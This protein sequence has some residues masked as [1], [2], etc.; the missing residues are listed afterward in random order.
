VL[1]LGNGIPY[2]SN[3]SGLSIGD[4]HQGGII[5]YLGSEYGGTGLIVSLDNAGSI[6]RW[7]CVTTN[8]SGATGHAIGTGAQN[9]S[10]IVAA[11]CG[12]TKPGELAN[13]YSSGG[14]TDWFL[15]SKDELLEIPPHLSIIEATAISNG[16][17]AFDA[18]FYWSSTEGGATVAYSVSFTT[19]STFG[20]S[21][22]GPKTNT[23]WVRAI[24][25][26]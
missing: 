18:Y 15:P 7:G 10:D 22:S 26:F 23:K 19:S 12:S 9:T 24:R 14:Y 25:A 16:G 1:G 21:F 4:F 17:S 5:F 20:N 3:V 13:N 6:T 2:S 11:G 8:I